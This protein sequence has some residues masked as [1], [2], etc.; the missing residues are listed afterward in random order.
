MIKPK[1]LKT[2]FKKRIGEIFLAIRQP[3]KNPGHVT[4]ASRIDNRLILR[5]HRTRM[6]CIRLTL[7]DDTANFRSPISIA[8]CRF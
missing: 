3:I 2:I 7:T 1:K 8:C 4:T 5:G 6:C